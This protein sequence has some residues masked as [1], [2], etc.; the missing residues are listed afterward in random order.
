MATNGKDGM[1]P[2][3]SSSVNIPDKK[4]EG[5]FGLLQNRGTKNTFAKQYFGENGY[6]ESSLRGLKEIEKQYRELEK[7]QSKMS[8]SQKKEFANKKKELEIQL[9]IL[10]DIKN[11]Q[12]VSDKEATKSIKE[13]NRI[14]LSGWEMVNKAMTQIADRQ[15]RLK[16]R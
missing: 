5:V 11:N 12:E 9:S 6:L 7:I 15:E 4:E 13:A 8:E 16:K 1:T 3:M 2:N 10:N 14:R